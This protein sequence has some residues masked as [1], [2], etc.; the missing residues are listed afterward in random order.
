MTKTAY[1]IYNKNT[2]RFKA[3]TGQRPQ[4]TEYP[5]QLY[6]SKG[7]AEAAL[8]V[9]QNHKVKQIFRQVHDIVVVEVTTTW[10]V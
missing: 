5:T 8:K 1:A 3:R 9:V 7:R 6:D 4:W 2:E 10:V